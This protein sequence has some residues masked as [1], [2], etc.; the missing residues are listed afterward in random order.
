MNGNL[1]KWLDK[2]TVE[3]E[4][5][6]TNTL[7]AF[8]LL[9][10]A[11]V[12][13]LFLFWESNVTKRKNYSDCL[14][15]KV[16]NV[17]VCF[18]IWLWSCEECVL[19]LTNPAGKQSLQLLPGCQELKTTVLNVSFLLLLGVFFPMQMLEEGAQHFQPA[20]TCV[21]CCLQI[22]SYPGNPAQTRRTR[23]P[24]MVAISKEPRAIIQLLLTSWGCKF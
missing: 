20:C 11:A 6:I 24:S 22:C 14:I 8:L 16:V 1:K 21:G 17:H 3:F 10:S 15:C 4:L 19:L 13:N 2:N 7:V 12:I 5:L 18:C 23:K 9:Q